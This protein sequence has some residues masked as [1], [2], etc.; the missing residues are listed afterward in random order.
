MLRFFWVLLA[1]CHVEHT[2]NGPGRAALDAIESE[3]PT[4]TACVAT[5]NPEVTSKVNMKGSVC[6]VLDELTVL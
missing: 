4:A 3:I 6:E 5:V 2:V 1:L